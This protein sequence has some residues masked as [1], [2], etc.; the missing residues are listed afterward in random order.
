MGR[1]E[2][3]TVSSEGAVEYQASR[4]ET[5]TMNLSSSELDDLRALVPAVFPAPEPSGPRVPDGV[6]STLQVDDQQAT[7]GTP[8]P[9]PDALLPLVQELGDIQERLLSSP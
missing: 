2:T 9:V 6:N 3:L 7:W 8:S 4:Q 5:Q 1:S